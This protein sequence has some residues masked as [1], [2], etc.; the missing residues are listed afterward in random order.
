MNL[1]TMLKQEKSTQKYYRQIIEQ[2][3]LDEF[4][5]VEIDDSK[6]TKKN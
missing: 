2:N 3:D 6:K 4:E 1:K 5:T